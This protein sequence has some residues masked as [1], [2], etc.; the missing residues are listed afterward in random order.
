VVDARSQTQGTYLAEK[1]WINKQLVQEDGSPDYTKP[2]YINPLEFVVDELIGANTIVVRFNRV[3]NS[4]LM[5]ALSLLRNTLP[6]YCALV[7]LINITATDDYLFNSSSDLAVNPSQIELVDTK[8]LITGSISDFDE[9]NQDI[10]NDTD[11]STGENLTKTAEALS[12]GI[13]PDILPDEYLV[14][15]AIQESV[16][17]RYEPDCLS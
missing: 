6:A 7:V 13:C 16:T 9:G 1:L 17:P 8:A 4:S 12:L 11:P 14:D 10:W 15:E 2:L 5:T 3:P